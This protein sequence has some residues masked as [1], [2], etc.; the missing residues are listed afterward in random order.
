MK[1]RQLALVSVLAVCA[2]IPLQIGDVDALEDGTIFYCYGDHRTLHYEYGEKPGVE[3]RWIATNED[4]ES[5][6]CTPDVGFE[7]AIDLSS[8]RYG[9]KVV[10]EQAV[11]KDGVLED[12]IS[13]VL[14]PL[15]IADTSYDITFMDGSKVFDVQY[16][17]DSTVVIGGQDHVVVPASPVKEGYAF[18]GWYTDTGFED[19]LDPKKP[20][21]GDMT[22]YAKWTGTGG[23]SSSGTV[24]IDKTH[25]VTF[26]VETGLHY[27]VVGQ[28]SNLVAFVVIVVGGY[29]LAEGSLSVTSDGGTITE[30][31]GSYN[32]T[33]I[34]RNIIVTISGDVSEISPVDPDPPVDPDGPNNSDETKGEFPWLIV[35]IL[36]LVIVALVAKLALSRRS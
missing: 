30:V 22:V 25:A 31:A 19:E 24:V 13:A 18:D 14:I 20:V 33:G 7:V 28:G 1:S 4:G 12:T 35:V 8:Q 21:T 10:V 36:I 34:D 11:Y 2:L 23:G 9:S 6:T 32:L 26:N 5:V 16:I 3:V 29:Q 17:T 15:H 27:E